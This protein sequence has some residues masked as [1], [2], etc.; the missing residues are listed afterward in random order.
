MVGE[1]RM[2]YPS[3]HERIGTMDNDE[4]IGGALYLEASFDRPPD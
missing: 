1:G 3:G 2:R 4:W